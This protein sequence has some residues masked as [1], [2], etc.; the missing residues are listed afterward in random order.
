MSGTTTGVTGPHGADAATSR[1]DPEA[2][3]QLI[4]GVA[5]D[6]DRAAFERIFRYYLPRLKAWG[7]R[8]GVSA[9]VA[10][11]LAQET[12]I[13]LWRR[14]TT[15]ERSRASASRWVYAIF[16]N[17]M[18]D[19][20]RRHPAR[21]TG[22]DQAAELCDHAADPESTA[23]LGSTGRQLQRAIAALPAEQAQVLRAVYYGN[24]SHREVA[25][26]F[27]LPIG[28]VKSRVRLALARIRLAVGGQCI[29]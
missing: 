29:Y 20:F 16:R 17:K 15:F 3:A 7:V 27:N 23:H 11:E 22:L 6:G 21:E 14:A 1:D 28:T 13:S 19:H 10:E 18:I 25:E 4:E 24:R 26:A 5:V 12:M 8:S 9:A 2:M